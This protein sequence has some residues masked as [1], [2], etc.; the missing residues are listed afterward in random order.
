[1]QAARR[2]SG[3]RG[4]RPRRP[5]SWT[6]RCTCACTTASNERAGGARHVAAR[7]ARPARPARLG[8]DWRGAG[9]GSIRRLPALS[10]TAP[11]TS[12][13][14]L[15]PPA[16]PASAYRSRGRVP[17]RMPA[18]AQRARESTERQVLQQSPQA[19]TAPPAPPP[20]LLLPLLNSLRPLRNPGPAGVGL[21]SDSTRRQRE[22]PY[23]IDLTCKLPLPG[24]W[25]ARSARPGL[26]WQVILPA[27]GCR[28]L[29]QAWLVRSWY[30]L[31]V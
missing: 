10:A 30:P 23:R 8:T 27:R 11:P 6:P 7:W 29:G 31:F 21:S 24:A 12:Q 15:P 4:W 13:D 25:S 9:R 14:F 28:L 5:R 17:Q 19:S 16:A 22:S 2:G 26:A 20:P 18:P 1:M 3:G